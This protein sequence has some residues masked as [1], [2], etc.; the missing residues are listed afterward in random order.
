M[1]TETGGAHHARSDTGR[2]RVQ[3]QGLAEAGEHEGAV[4]RD[5]FVLR[6]EREPAGRRCSVELGLDAGEGGRVAYG[7][8]H[9]GLQGGAGGVGAGD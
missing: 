3:A 9:E 8:D 5:L 7:E 1:D 6:R 4:R 2:W